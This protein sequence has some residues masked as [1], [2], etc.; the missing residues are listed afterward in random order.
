MAKYKKLELP[1]QSYLSN[2]SIQ[3]L[4]FESRNKRVFI[5]NNQALIITDTTT[6]E[7]TSATSS[8]TFVKPELVDTERFIKLY[9]LGIDELM[10]LSA[11]GLKVFKL[12]YV[13]MREH[14]NTD[15]FT[16]DFTSLRT[17]NLWK[18]SQPTF[19]NGLNELLSRNVLFKS[20]YPAQ[21]FVNVQ[22]FFNGDRINI[23]KSYKL[24]QTDMFDEQELLG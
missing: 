3:S 21:Y 8:A 7:Q 1:L 10:N 18:W 24:K 16:L 22:Y 13:M 11:S 14:P 5:K 19:N 20:V 2:P 17:F 6:G 15:L 4:S 23:V 9:T 12:I